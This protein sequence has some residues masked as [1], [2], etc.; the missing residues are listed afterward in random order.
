[1]LPATFVVTNA[2][3]SG[4][5]SLR[6][7]IMSV[8][9][10]THPYS[11]D[12]DVN[13]NH[14]V[15][16]TIKLMSAL[17]TIT[18]QVRIFG[19]DGGYGS[20]E[21]EL[22]GSGLV[23]T[24]PGAAGLSIQAT[25]QDTD[26]EW[27]IQGFKID[28]FI[29]GIKIDNSGSST[30]FHL[31]VYNNDI[32]TRAG[33][34]GVVFNAGTGA[35]W[36]GFFYNSITTHG[37]SD[38]IA[39]QTAGT[40]D[41]FIFEG[42][43]IST[44]GAGDAIRVRGDALASTLTFVKNHLSA[45]TQ[46]VANLDFVALNVTLSTSSKAYVAVTN[47]ELST[48][49]RGTGLVLQGG[50]AFQALVQGNNFNGN[51]LGV[52]VFGDGTTAGNVDL[53]GGSLGSKGGNDFTSY[54][55]VNQPYLYAIGLFKV[56]PGYT[57]KAMG[58]KFSVSPELVIV[59][60]SYDSL[61]GGS[62]AILTGAAAFAG[63][64]A[65]ERF[66]QALYL[67]QLG[68]AGMQSELDAWLP[69][70]AGPGAQQ[71][72]VAGIAGS[73]EAQDHLVKNWYQTYLGRPANGT[74][75]LGWVSLLQAGQSEEQVLGQFLGSTEFYNRAQTMGL[76]GTA[77]QNYVQA[78]YQVLLGRTAGDAEVAGWVNALPQ[79]GT[80]GVALGFL[81]SQEYRT[82]QVEGYYTTLLHRPADPAGLN[83]WVM[84]NLDMYTARLGFEASPEFFANG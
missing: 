46:P 66:V 80:Q 76:A 75:E 60:G 49:N 14:A 11:D 18:R 5:G 70:L 81:Q 79:L 7:A 9:A 31:G 34:A 27:V 32:V 28:N 37:Y 33:G 21:I 55:E 74:E 84:S 10:D 20:R 73:F 62:G 13:I 67:D 53:G 83:N 6:S 56:A 39:V 78:L 72:V 65:Q 30:R 59:D 24:A 40:T 17:P 4:P 52:S 1:M 43:E 47:N 26:F 50:P 58:N 36:G 35:T 41:R 2:S 45:D 82:D 19:Y 25:G 57:M 38:G 77:D 71:A 61:G 3:D 48:H 16:Q 15:P 12:I 42:N 54:H 51:R 63:L 69:V 44:S 29:T 8:N 23:R 64:S 68:R 22:D